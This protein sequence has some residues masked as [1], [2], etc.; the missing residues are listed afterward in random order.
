LRL[1][2]RRLGAAALP[3]VALALL[4]GCGGNGKHSTSAEPTPPHLQ[5]GRVTAAAYKRRLAHINQEVQASTTKVRSAAQNAKTIPQLRSALLAYANDQLRIGTE[6]GLILP[7]KQANRAN[8][9]LAQGLKAEAMQLKALLPRLSKFKN[10]RAAL[11]MIQHNRPKGAQEL[12]KA[13]S[14]LKQMGL[15]P[16]SGASGG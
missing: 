11:I 10:P 2:L 12:D 13:V 14:E 7:P 8:R 3:L 9:M 6:V 5:H 15:S 4:A 1:G 16:G